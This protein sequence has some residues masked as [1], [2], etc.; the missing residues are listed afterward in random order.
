MDFPPF[1]LPGGHT[2]TTPKNSMF[3]QHTLEIAKGMPIVGVKIKMCNKLLFY[4]ELIDF[5][6]FE[7]R[8]IY[9]QEP[10]RLISKIILIIY[11]DIL[12]KVGKT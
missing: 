5:F 9:I 10:I 12:R 11:L 2:E 3:Y 4:N 7:E 1:G 8:A 6:D